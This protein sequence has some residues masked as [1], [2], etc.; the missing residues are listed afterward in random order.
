VSFTQHGIIHFSIRKRIYSRKKGKKGKKKGK[1]K[2]QHGDYADR[3]FLPCV[4]I[5]A[6][7]FAESEGKQFDEVNSLSG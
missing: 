2:M 4:S 6:V 7:S 3:T 5:L 1:K